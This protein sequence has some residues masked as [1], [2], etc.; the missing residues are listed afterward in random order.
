MKRLV[1]LLV[2]LFFSIKEQ[3]YAQTINIDSLFQQVIGSTDSQ[4]ISLYSQIADYYLKTSPESSII[5][6]QE[7][8][9]LI[10][11]NDSELKAI[12]LGRFGKA[13][14]KMGKYDSSLTYHLQ[15]LEIYET[16]KYEVGIARA[17]NELGLI[18]RNLNE[19][20]EALIYY[21][22]AL[23]IAEQINN[24]SL[25]AKIL[26]GIAGVYY[27]QNKFN[28]ALLNLKKA[29]Q[30]NEEINDQEN[31]VAVYNNKGIIYK[32]LNQYSK[33]L[34]NYNKSLNIKLAQNNIHGIAIS[35]AN[36]GALYI[37]LNDLKKA[38]EILEKGIQLVEQMKSNKLLLIYFETF[39][40]L[41]ATKKDYEKAF[42]YQKKYTDLN[43]MVLSKESRD[44]IA[45]LQAEFELSQRNKELEIV[46]K[47]KILNEKNSRIISFSLIVITLFLFFNILSIFRRYKL[48]KISNELLKKEIK[49]HKKTSESLQI[50]QE[51]FAL[52]MQGSNDGL[53][54][55]DL[56][57]N[58][59]YYSDRW[60]S[61]LGYNEYE[62]QNDVKA[63][64]DSIHPNDREH[65]IKTFKDHLDGKTELYE[66][67]FRIRHKDGHYICVHDR[68][69][70][71]K[72]GMG[73]PI[74]AV[75]THTDIS[76]KKKIEDELKE[77]QEHLE[78]LV[79][80]RTQELN[81]AKE[82]AEESDHLKSAFLANMS[83][84]I[85]TPMNAIIGFSDLL[86]DPTIS[87]EQRAEFI[88]HINKNSDSL[89][90]IIDD[91]IDI[92]KI[93]AGQLTI[94]KTEC[95]I[96]QVLTEV[97]NSFF[98]TNELKN[99]T[100]LKFELIKGI[101]SDYFT[102]RTDPFRLKQIIIN[103]VSN[104]LK[105]TENGN[106]E[107][108]YIV[109]SDEDK[110]FLEFYVSDTGIG[111]P[112]EK[113]NDIFERFTKLENCK[114]KLYRGTGLGLT[115]TKNLVEILGGKIWVNS[116]PNIG[117]TF[118]FTIPVEQFTG[119][120]E[121]QTLKIDDTYKDWS[122]K[123]ILIAEDEDSNFRVLQ[124][125]L[126]RTNIKITRAING[127]EAIEICKSDMGIDLVLM[128]I[129]MP[130][131]NGIDA[132]ISIKKDRPELQIIAQTAFAMAE[133][134]TQILDAGC[135]DYLSKPIKS[136]KL[137]A[138]L[139]KYL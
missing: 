28:E 51:R 1:I 25:E 18:Y 101:Q 39:A 74:R 6:S 130:E 88:D 32:N 79:Q 50:S 7:A 19:F 42:E 44:N 94:N 76:E 138:V 63:F 134:K 111:I 73:E 89:L 85:R 109:K 80:F 91:I 86:G 30:I 12:L 114:T 122:D 17:L 2:I 82:K 53:W 125:I 41:Y 45:Q 21:N 27:L 60:K 13:F 49:E 108:G 116:T 34:E 47:E 52:A 20:K 105:Y 124:V 48:K 93:E 5:Y 119:K 26:S 83:H 81:D 11:N 95:N 127:L 102:I 40:D 36:I 70:A 8:L 136:R 104:A 55:R 110:S 15:S 87:K 84:E 132:T 64:E 107:L 54:D 75:G 57:T 29:E 37:K 4:K 10:G 121:I 118:F 22:K 59:V 115:I 78:E 58:T 71:I 66:N 96:N 117:S 99:N 135:I 113:H 72:N 97:Y 16:L 98:E 106:I 103:L 56:T 9:K 35:Y 31:L 61:M 137:F 65:V 120:L 128:D 46:A 67:I 62:F 112:Q 123:K 131:M 23:N 139:N 77:Y 69:K 24:K 68:G 100:Q 33:A 14:E 38:E 92:A 129:K 133:D 90:Y 43:E 126:K 3:I